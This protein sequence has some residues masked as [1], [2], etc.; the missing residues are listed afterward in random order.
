[1]APS[2]WWE[3]QLT[4]PLPN[5]PTPHPGGKECRWQQRTLLKGRGRKDNY[6]IIADKEGS[7]LVNDLF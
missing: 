4:G 6:E 3:T 2:F 1:M 7:E 5:P